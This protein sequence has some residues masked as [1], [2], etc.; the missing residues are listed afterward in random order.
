MAKKCFFCQIQEEG[1]KFIA[2][3]KGFYSIYDEKP[4][5]QGDALVVPKRH[6]SSI[7]ELKDEEI[8]GMHECIKKTRKIIK[9]R[10]NPDGYNMGVN[11][12]EAADQ[13]M[14]HFHFH[15]IPRYK[16]R[17]LSLY[18]IIKKYLY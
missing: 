1:T 12:G 7:L 10:F 2:E 11:E 13:T 9:K 18:K 6:V 15:I 4:V 16:G 17:F 8:L 3:N 5:S 14:F